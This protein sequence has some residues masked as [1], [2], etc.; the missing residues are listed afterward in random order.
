V[1]RRA[2]HNFTLAQLNYFFLI[3]GMVVAGAR[4]WPVAFGGAP[5]EVAN[6]AE[7]VDTVRDLGANIA[8]LVRRLHSGEGK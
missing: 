4:Y 3:N 8:W 2:G 7:G 1:G 5:G 6:D